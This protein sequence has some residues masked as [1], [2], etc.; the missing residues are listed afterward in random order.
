MI[1]AVTFAPERHFEL[2]APRAL[3]AD[4]I[5]LVWASL[6]VGD[7]RLE[8]LR[9]SLHADERARIERLYFERDRRRATASRGILRELLAGVLD[10][11]EVDLELIEGAHG[12]P[13]LRSAALDFNVS[14]TEEHMVVALA[15]ARALGVDVEAGTGLLDVD[16]IAP[17]VFTRGEQAELARYAGA[18]RR[19]A[20]LRGWARKE[21]Y[22]KARSVGLSLPLADFEVSLG[23][24][25][26]GGLRSVVDPDEA[27]RFVVLGLPAPAGCAAALAYARDGEH[28][29]LRITSL[30]GA[31]EVR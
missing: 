27:A 1:G 2:G 10:A 24:G 22:L 5:V 18:A 15:R 21:A 20:F 14:H 19:D 8:T 6:Q 7:A 31:P 26:D 28:L 16:E 3:A 30:P 23:A 29:R 17:S 13:A 11:R 25:D 4:E 12:K 9:A